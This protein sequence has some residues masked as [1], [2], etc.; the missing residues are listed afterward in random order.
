MWNPKNMFTAQPTKTYHDYFSLYLNI[1]KY[2]KK[3]YGVQKYLIIGQTLPSTRKQRNYEI[4]W[5]ICR[6]LKK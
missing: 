2:E 3:K 4:I 6:F 1:S 5:I